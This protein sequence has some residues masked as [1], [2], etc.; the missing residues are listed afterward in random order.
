MA[1]LHCHHCHWSQ[2]DFWDTGYNPI[3]FME[4]NYTKELLKG[5]LDRVIELQTDIPFTKKVFM[6]KMTEREFIAKEMERKART[7]R[8][9]IYRTMEEF[10]Q[11]NPEQKCPNCGKK[12]LDID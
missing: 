5:D 7:V 8:N 12:E 11:K 3:T 1:Y 4:H 2:D 10:K 6:A 9:M